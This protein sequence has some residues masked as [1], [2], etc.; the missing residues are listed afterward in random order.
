MT[1]LKQSCNNFVTIFVTMCDS[2]IRFVLSLY[3][4]CEEE[5]ERTAMMKKRWPEEIDWIR[6]QDQKMYRLINILSVA[7]MLFLVCVIT[8][9]AASFG[10]ESVPEEDFAEVIRL[11]ASEY[12]MCMA[13]VPVQDEQQASAESGMTVQN[14]SLQDEQQVSDESCMAVLNVSAQDEQQMEE[15]ESEYADLS[16]ARVNNSVDDRRALNKENDVLD[17]S[18]DGCR[19]VVAETQKTV[20]GV[21]DDP[22]RYAALRADCRNVRGQPGI[23]ADGNLSFGGQFVSSG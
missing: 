15:R 19:D 2:R 20:G 18:F 8:Y 7:A 21:R 9:R 1:S 14:A 6:Q 23:T 17:M 12:Q 10:V 13:D 16:Y 3:Q 4:I 5:N 11:T 22:A